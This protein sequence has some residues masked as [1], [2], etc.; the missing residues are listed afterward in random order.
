MNT[1]EYMSI[2]RELE[3]LAERQIKVIN[4]SAQA[5]Q[6]CIFMGI[7]ILKKGINI[8]NGQLLSM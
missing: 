3:A 4:N 2:N 1:V 7:K 6:P 8:I 5:I